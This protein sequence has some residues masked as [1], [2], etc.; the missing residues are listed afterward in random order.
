MIP[1]INLRRQFAFIKKELMQEIEEVIESGQYI[2]GRRVKELEEKIKERL[3]VSDAIGV[4]NGTDA[5][6]LILEGF[7]IG[8]GD[9]VITT[10]FTFF[11]TA[12]AISR[13]GAKPVFVDIDP[14]TYNLDMSRVE[15]AITPRTKAILP[16]HLFGQPADMEPLQEAARRHSL[17][18]FE[19]AC[20]AFGATYRGKPVGSLGDAASFSFFPTK[21][22]GTLGDG[23]LVATSHQG[24]AERIRLLRQHGSRRKYEHEKIGMNSRLDEIHA[25]VLLLAL[26]EI[27]QWNRLRR[28][29]VAIYLAELADLP[30]LTLPRVGEGREPVW[31]LFSVEVES[32]EMVR[33]FLQDRGIETGVYYPLSLHLQE[34]YRSLGYK[35]GDLP[36]AER[37]SKRILALPLS[38]F[39]SEAEQEQVISAL[40]EYGKKEGGS[41]K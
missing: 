25:A 8:P 39:L 41:G 12:E 38:P 37:V 26:K 28:E 13:A 23:G 27:D 36:V 15:E 3:E 29:K 1:L 30:F 19:D 40:R 18:L 24:V 9:E 10:P 35:E 7:G 4:G 20:Q 5:L 11:A 16:V 17:F 14:V 34:A 32:R 2:L 22:L 21:N 6:L 31:H 33:K